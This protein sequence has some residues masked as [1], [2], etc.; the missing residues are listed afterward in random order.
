LFVCLVATCTAA[1]G[2]WCGGLMWGCMTREC[3]KLVVW[4]QVTHEMVDIL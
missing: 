4:I 3:F 1:A 2:A